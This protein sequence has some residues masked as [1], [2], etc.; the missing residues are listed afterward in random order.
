MN[1]LKNIY[2]IGPT[3]TSQKQLLRVPDINERMKKENIFAHRTIS[4]DAIYLILLDLPAEHFDL[5]RSSML[6]TFFMM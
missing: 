1:L 2:E 3:C 4:L 5:T 6:V